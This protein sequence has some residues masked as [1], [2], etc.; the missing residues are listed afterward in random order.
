MRPVKVF[1]AVTSVCALVA[2]SAVGAL[3]DNL[4]LITL[5][6]RSQEEIVR[7]TVSRAYTRNG[8]DMLCSIDSGQADVLS[9]SGVEFKVVLSGIDPAST[10]LVR[11]RRKV[12]PDQTNMKKLGPVYDL[13]AGTF[14]STMSRTAAADL[15]ND[16]EYF[17]NPLEQFNIRIVYLPPA[18]GGFLSELGD[19]PSDSVAN[20][21][22]MDSLKAWDVRLENFRTRYIGTDSINAARDWIMQKFHEWGYTDVT[23]PYFYLDG[24]LVFNIKVVKPGYAEPDVTI[25]IGGH[26]DSIVYGQAQPASV[27]APGADDNGTGTALTMEL[28]RVFKDIPFRKTIIFMPFTA[29]EQGLVGSQVAAQD[30][31]NAG[32][33]LEVMMNWDMVA[34]DPSS[35]G[36]LNVAAGSND[37]YLSLEE[38]ACQRVA[39]SLSL[40]RTA[41]G[42]GSDHRSFLDQGFNIVDHIETDF[43]YPGWHTNLDLNTRLNFPYFT[44]VAK[45]AAATLAI[46]LDA[47]HPTEIRKI[48]DQGDGHSVEVFWSDCSPA[49][50]YRLYWGTSSGYYPNSVT[51]APGH[52]SYVVSGLTEGTTYYF[53]AVGSIPGGYPAVYAVEGTGESYVIPRQPAGMIASPDLN[54]IQLRWRANNEADL[55]HYR[56]YRHDGHYSLYRDNVTD[57]VFQDTDVMGH[58]EYRYVVAAVDNDGHESVTSSEVRSMAATFD[59]GMLVVD[60]ISEGFGVPD[61]AG[62]VTFFNSLL[63]AGNYAIV[64]IDAEGTPLTRNTAGQYSSI[65]WFDDDIASHKFISLSEDSLSWYLDYT[66]NMFISGFRT[67]E[68]W[69]ESQQ[70]HA[71]DVLYDD[72]GLS[73]FTYSTSQDFV[74]AVGQ[75]GC[76]SVSVDTTGVMKAFPF[77]PVLTARAGAQVLYTFD[78]KTD[79]PAYEGRPCGLLWQTT[80]G[81]RVLLAFP[82]LHM[83]DPTGQALVDRVRTLFNESGQVYPAGDANR[84]GAVNIADVVYL[85]TYFFGGGAAPVDPNLA[86]MNH[87]CAVGVSDV[88]YLLSFLFSSGP[89]P[90][91]G[92]VY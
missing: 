21:I 12:V 36:Q 20:R 57:T 2:L 40:L 83:T 13:G 54:S 38:A 8:N 17:V 65:L 68:Y 26:Y 5:K 75:N 31:V 53:S 30:F 29:E 37:A 1:F 58:L 42:S 92:C 15:E 35:A 51:I 67:I 59:G 49:Y 74:G 85:L 81:K 73:G 86:D 71:G 47:A 10:Y 41:P 55:S 80:H 69:G 32:T 64:S 23:A 50:Q 25:V 78:S 56:I 24:T 88:T 87:S 43:N 33:N 18:I 91:S 16:P 90:K 60:E 39:G 66:D 61:Q 7:G 19:Y 79:N 84:S 63:G 48:V 22:N 52:C 82:V 9:K 89:P 14:V 70:F 6:S 28:A 44:Q 34:Y 4:G 62:Q 72:F 77:V 3:A 27:Y 46:V 11:A 76:P 45:S